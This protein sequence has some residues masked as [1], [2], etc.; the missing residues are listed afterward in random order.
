MVICGGQNVRVRKVE[1]PGH[2]VVYG[3][4][5]DH[6]EISIEFESNEEAIRKAPLMV[7]NTTD[8]MVGAV[9]RCIGSAILRINGL[10]G[11]AA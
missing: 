7:R 6:A 1:L 8:D 11:A 3:F 2:R 10:S 4:E 9:E 5:R